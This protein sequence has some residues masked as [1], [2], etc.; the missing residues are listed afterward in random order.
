MFSL[1]KRWSRASGGE[2]YL[3]E[4]GRCADFSEFLPE[5][6]LKSTVYSA[7]GWYMY[8]GADFSEFLQ[9][10]LTQTRRW[11][12]PPPRAFNVRRTRRLERGTRMSTITARI[13]T[14]WRLFRG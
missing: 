7:H 3:Q 12:W 4:I 9:R 10:L 8:Q 14:L 11:K 5:H 13:M 2:L 6:I 1:P